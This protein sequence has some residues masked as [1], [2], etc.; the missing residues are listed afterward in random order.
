MTVELALCL[1]LVFAAFPVSRSISAHY[2]LFA[3]VNGAML[4]FTSFDASLL[5][6]VFMALA[7]ADATLFLFGGRAILLISAAVSSLLCFES[8]LNMDWLLSQSTYI[9]A[10]VNA[11]IVAS[12]IKGKRNWTRGK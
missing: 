9:N 1:I 5:A 10:A 3:A 2:F 6:L 4:G 11:V 8:M 12:L 7:I